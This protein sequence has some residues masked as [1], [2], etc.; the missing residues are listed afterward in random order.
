MKV[1]VLCGGW[2]AEREVSLNS[3]R[4]VW[5]A[6]RSRGVEAE[7]FDPAER[8]LWQLADAGFDR[9]FVALHGRFGEDGT[10]QGALEILRIPYTGSGVAASALGMDKLRSKLVWRELGIPTPAWELAR[11]DGAA[12]AG[13]LGLPLMVKPAHEG[14]SIGMSL[15][16]EREDLEPA[17]DLARRYD[18]SVLVEAFIRGTELTAAIVN[19]RALPLIRLETPHAFYDYDAKYLAADTRYHCPAG[20]DDVL[21]ASLRAQAQEAFETLGCRGWGRVDLM[22]DEQG[23]PWFLEVNT[24]PGMTDHSLVPMAAKAAGMDYADLV[25]AILEG[26]SLDPLPKIDG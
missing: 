5:E 25:L 6:L 17:L 20:L 11:D 24:A 4:M 2:S 19:G 22:L 23:R 1:A 21:E 13:R 10:V 12:I 7:R 8:P 9:A 26:A 15:V 16:R 18:A 14:S 3:G